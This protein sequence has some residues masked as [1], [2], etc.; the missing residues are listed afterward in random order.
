MKL[1]KSFTLAPLALALGVSSAMIFAPTVAQAGATG[2]IGVFSKYVLYGITNNTENDGTTVQGGFDWSADSGFYLGYWGSNLDYGNLTTETG[3]ENDFY[4]GYAGKAG[5]V[6]Y[7]V[8]LIQYYYMGVDDSDGLEFVGTV[9]FG[10]L[11]GGFEC[12]TK[13]VAWGNTGDIYWSLTYSTKLPNNF[14]LDA[15]LGYYTYEDEGDFI[16]STPEDGGFRH[17]DLTLYHA[18]GKT[19]A[20][21]SLTYIIGGDDR[22]GNEQ[23]NALV[24]GVKYAFDM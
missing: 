3:F 6:S 18:I 23:E 13:D 12:L 21:M 20:G 19:G 16:A 7:S 14:G 2:H 9:G 22:N 5:D 8:G 17:L 15:T 24:L 1:A 10:P 11:T 4:G